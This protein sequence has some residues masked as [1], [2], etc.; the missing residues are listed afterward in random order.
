MK[1]VKFFLMAA[2][3]VWAV[4]LSA[5]TTRVDDKELIGA[6]TLEWMQFD[7]EK[8][9]VCGKDS[10]YTQFKYYGP[11]GEYA[12]A[13]IALN[14]EGKCVVMPHEYGKYT[15]KDGVYSEMGRPAVKPTDMVLVDKTHFKGR[16]MNRTDSWKKQTGMPDKVVKYI[17][18]CCKLK[19]M[20]ADVEQLVKEYMF[21][22]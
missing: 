20:P 19:N 10:K 15:F 2:T 8:K 6:W 7:G 22:K 13:E 5:Q 21:E 14:K 11:D 16:W 18:N 9:I 4:Q 17:V 3:L 12:C 1:R